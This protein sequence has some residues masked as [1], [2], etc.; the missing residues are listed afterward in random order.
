MGLRVGLWAMNRGSSKQDRTW[1][2]VLLDEFAMS[3]G[4]ATFLAYVVVMAAFALLVW[5]LLTGL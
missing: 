3:D 1:I 4:C 2:E 5:V